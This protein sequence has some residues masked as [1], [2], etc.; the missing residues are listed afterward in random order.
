MRMIVAFVSVV[1]TAAVLAVG[2]CGSALGED[3]PENLAPS[4]KVSAS[5]QFSDAYRPEMATSGVVP[6]EFQ[7]DS[8]WAV[9]ATQAGHFTLQWDKPVTAAQ[10][11]YY[12]RVTSPLLE[13][14]KD[15]AIY[16]DDREQPVVRGT[17][18]H[19]PI[20]HMCTGPD[21]HGVRGLQR[22]CRQPARTHAD[23]DSAPIQWR[24]QW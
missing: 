10:I 3:V 8:D 22:R 24:R 18:E 1:L 19:R 11:I 21:L 14:F 7:Q 15:F 20:P 13:C 16:V 12:A 6:S 4:A 23:A 9:R 17:L 5:S 2:F